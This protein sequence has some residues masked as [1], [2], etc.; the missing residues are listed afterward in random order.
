MKIRRKAGG[1]LIGN[2]FRRAISNISIMGVNVGAW[3]INTFDPVPTHDSDGS[4]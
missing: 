2:F 1:T 4:F 3:A